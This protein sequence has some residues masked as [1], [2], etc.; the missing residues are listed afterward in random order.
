VML[1]NQAVL[2][3]SP[4][5]M[6]LTFILRSHSTCFNAEPLATFVSFA[7]V[8]FWSHDSGDA[9]RR[10]GRCNLAPRVSRA[11]SSGSA[12]PAP[13]AI[14]PPSDVSFRRLATAEGTSRWSAMCQTQTRTA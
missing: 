13:A 9:D 14:R 10:I 3:M 12:Q 5:K 1:A 8:S 6:N 2:F 4:P 7:A 11:T